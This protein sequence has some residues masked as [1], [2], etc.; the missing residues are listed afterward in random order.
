LRK[1]KIGEKLFLVHIRY[2]TKNKS[3]K[4]ICIVKRVGKKYFYVSS[5]DRNYE[6]QFYIEDWRE[7]TNY[8]SNYLLYESE[9]EY[10]KEIKKEKY[11]KEIKNIFD[12]Y[13]SCNK[14]SF[15]QIEQ[16]A[17]ILNIKLNNLK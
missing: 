1:P 17:K 3:K 7:K 4:E 6:I 5:K 14:Y 11:I 13:G 10:N 12:R 16:T 2:Y 15:E 8:C 9:E